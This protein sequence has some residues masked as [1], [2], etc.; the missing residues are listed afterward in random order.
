MKHKGLIFATIGFF[1]ILNT[2]YF[3]EGELKL[4]A[5]PVFMLLLMSYVILGFVLLQ[6]LFLAFKEKFVDRQRILAAAFLSAVL[7][8]TYFRPWGVIDFD[9]L[10]GEDLLV[11]EA[12][13]G[14]NCSTTLK[15]KDN[16][17]FV[18]RSVCFGLTET[19]GFYE[20]KGDTILFSGSNDKYYT[21]AI[22]KKREFQNE[23]ISSVLIMYK[24]RTDTTGLE[25]SIVKNGLKI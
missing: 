12:E 10:S 23:P 21:Y 19:K 16:N 25:L 18:E 3:W 14:G 7:I 11:A 24:S 5:F 2:S 22:L 9:T 6:Q 4:L 20:L 15:L 13:G 8:V 17:K 1:L